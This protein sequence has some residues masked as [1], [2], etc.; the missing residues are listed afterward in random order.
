M[1]RG[2]S[3][4]LTLIGAGCVGLVVMALGLAFGVPFGSTGAG[5]IP[6]ADLSA[7]G[8]DLRDGFTV[9]DGSVL[10]GP[11]VVTNVNMSRGEADQWQAIVLVEGD[12]VEVWTAYL[13]Q[14]ATF[15]GK[16]DLDPDSATG[17]AVSESGH[18]DC[19]LTAD[20][21]G[22]EGPRRVVSMGLD[23]V[24][25]DVTGSYLMHLAVT[26][27]A[28]HVDGDAAGSQRYD[29]IS[30]GPWTGDDVPDPEDARERPPVG[31]PLAP[32]TVAEPADNKRFVLLAGSSLIAQYGYGSSLGGFDLV[33][34]VDPGTNP[35]RLA[36]KYAMQVDGVTDRMGTRFV[37]IGGTTV[38]EL[39]VGGGMQRYFG[40]VRAVDQPRDEP[41]Y[42]LYSVAYR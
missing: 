32:E 39:P 34:A 26:T 28:A 10:V 11:V 31:G 4:R 35:M 7:A 38:Y 36:E 6:R 5:D 16:K 17:C 18:L 37:S 20:T 8:T 27:D 30:T 22:T 12:P 42:I 14:V 29:V 19:G 9:A 41:D 1:V 15:L 23:S 21:P 3:W 25:G 33:L 24:P 40:T 2:L 13:S